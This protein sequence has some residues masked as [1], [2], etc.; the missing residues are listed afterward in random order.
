M[1]QRAFDRI[2][3]AALIVTALMATAWVTAAIA[4]EEN[5]LIE[6]RVE[7]ISAE[8]MV[9]YP[10]GM[11]IAP[12]GTSAIKIDLSRLPQD[13]YQGLTAGDSVV[14]TGTVAARR[15]RVIATSIR[16]RFAS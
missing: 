3:G 10:Y 1:R 2:P 4:L 7:W 9:V 5:V 12:V 16:R 15:D 6:G 8:N 13:Q 11:V 14:V